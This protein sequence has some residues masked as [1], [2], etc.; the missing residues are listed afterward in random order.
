MTKRI[1]QLAVLWAVILALGAGAGYWIRQTREAREVQAGERVAREVA[2]LVSRGRQAE[3]A[4]DLAGAEA[5]WAQAAEALERSGGTS[6][7]PPY[8][9][10]LVDLA[11]VRLRLRPGET[12]GVAEVRA[13]LD[14]AWSAPGLPPELRNRI[15]RDQGA[16]AVLAGDLT[17]AQRWYAEGGDASPGEPA[18]Q[19]RLEA[20]RRALEREAPRE[21]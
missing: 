14:R 15:A 20:L 21:R 9:V 3:A 6:H 10:L 12:A 7:G 18:A 11:S 5:S 1:S 2:Q 17:A 8:A 19:E 13:L 4:G 16:A